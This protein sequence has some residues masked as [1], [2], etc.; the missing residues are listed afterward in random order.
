MY[1]GL[2]GR[3]RRRRHTRRE[4]PAH[5]FFLTRRS[6]SARAYMSTCSPSVEDTASSPPQHYRHA[7]APGRDAPLHWGR[8]NRTSRSSGNQMCRTRTMWKTR[9]SFPLQDVHEDIGRS[10]APA[11][12]QKHFA[13]EPGARRV[14]SEL[15]GPQTEG[16]ERVG[17]PPPPGGASAAGGCVQFAARGAD[18]VAGLPGGVLGASR[19]IQ[20]SYS[21]PRSPGAA[22]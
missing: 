22:M 8:V 7:H 19:K 6:R 9:R 2:W 4:P 18:A 12:A 11:S 3:R 16:R 5:G 1:L 17:A 20:F 13:T 15:R 21:S 10:Q 14:S